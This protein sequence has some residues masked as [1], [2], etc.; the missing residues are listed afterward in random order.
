MGVDYI[1]KTP[2]PLSHLFPARDSIFICEPSK[3]YLFIYNYLR[4]KGDDVYFVAKLPASAIFFILF[5][6]A[7]IH[8]NSINC[9]NAFYICSFFIK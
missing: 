9:K 3:H 1:F 6:K 5:I 2:L 7:I 4:L 8:S